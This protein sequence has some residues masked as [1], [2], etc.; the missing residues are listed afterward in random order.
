MDSVIS[1]PSETVTQLPAEIRIVLNHVR[2]E[3]YEHLLA[4]LSDESAIRLTYVDGSLE[5]M[6]PSDEH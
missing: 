4:D 1:S 2:W 5:I 3:T 6:S